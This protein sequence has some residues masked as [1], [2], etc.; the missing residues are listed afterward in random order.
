ME[1]KSKVKELLNTEEPQEIVEIDG[2]YK[3]YDIKWLK[4]NPQH[5]DFYLVA[6][7]EALNGEKE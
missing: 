3:G 5:P 2:F 6:E 1:V 7:F 4:K